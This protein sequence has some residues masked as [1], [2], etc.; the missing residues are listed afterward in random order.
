ME[1][2]MEF[3]KTGKRETRKINTRHILFIVSGAF[4]G[5]DEIIKKR[6]NRQGMGFGAQIKSR[7]E[8]TEY[9]RLTKTE[10]LIQYGF[11]SEFVGRLPVVTVFENLEVE[12]LYHILRNP[13]SPIITSKKKDFKAYG[14]DLQF[15][16]ESLRLIAENAAKERTGAR[17]LVSAV[18]RVLIKFEHV[19]PSTS[20]HYLVVTPAMVNDPAGELRKLLQNPEDPEREALFKKLLA[21]E[22]S[23]L[24]SSIREKC[25]EFPERYGITF[26]DQRI[27]LISRRVVE[28]RK[29]LDSVVVEV[30]AVYHSAR[31]FEQDFSSRNEVKLTF[32]EEAIDRLIE[33]VW[34]RNVD[35]EV[36][37]EQTFQNYEHGLKLI[38]KKTGK[39]E[40]SIS[41]CC[42]DEPENY[43][44]ELIRESYK[45]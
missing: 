26:S 11:E 34:D 27:K 12:D 10:D 15:E 29:D 44:N 36:F 32:T 28:E 13:K 20:I 18:E 43:L 4:S 9:L 14:I 24:E 1:A 41:A 37:L 8:K 25:L 35:A 6:L 33:V 40:F 3:Q 19:L 5:L 22:E 42:I 31:N 7:D 17:G 38:R 23:A 45:T 16:D 30:L 21:E 2:M 39:K